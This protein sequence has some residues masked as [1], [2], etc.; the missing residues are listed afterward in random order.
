MTLSLLLQYMNKLLITQYNTIILL[1]IMSSLL[2]DLCTKCV[3]I[4]TI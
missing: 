1:K 2:A 4:I 3:N